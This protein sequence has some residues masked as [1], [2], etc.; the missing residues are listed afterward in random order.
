MY[1]LVEN[2]DEPKGEK[3]NVVPDKP[4]I[5]RCMPI[6][7]KTLQTITIIDTSRHIFGGFNATNLQQECHLKPYIPLP[8]VDKQTKTTLET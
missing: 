4:F 3:L 5:V 8:R 1:K 7:P 6:F 2:R